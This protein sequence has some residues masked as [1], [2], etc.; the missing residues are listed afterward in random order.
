MKYR[1]V[2]IL[3]VVADTPA[4]PQGETAESPSPVASDSST[5]VKAQEAIAPARTAAQE[6]PETDGSTRPAT[7]SGVVDCI[8][9]WLPAGFDDRLTNGRPKQRF[10]LSGNPGKTV[11]AVCSRRLR[12]AWGRA[13]SRG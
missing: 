9:C 2:P 7:G 3:N 6:T 11:I 4:F 13:D 12:T 1:P 10:Q 5:S 8:I